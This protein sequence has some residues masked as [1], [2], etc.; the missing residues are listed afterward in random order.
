MLMDN[1]EGLDYNTVMG[2]SVVKEETTEKTSLTR[3]ILSKTPYLKRFID[4][5]IT[6]K[7]VVTEHHKGL[8]EA[9]VDNLLTTATADAKINEKQR[10]KN[11]Q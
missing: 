7:T 5:S 1:V 8:N 9:E 2:K 11:Q 4:E 6:E 10:K 3:K